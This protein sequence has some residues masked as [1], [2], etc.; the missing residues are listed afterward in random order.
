MWVGRSSRVWED[1]GRLSLLP[2]DRLT[3][4]WVAGAAFFVGGV[5]RRAPRAPV[6]R[7]DSKIAS[8]PAG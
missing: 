2:F 7:Q 5:V 4:G 3:L 6:V 8:G 1:R